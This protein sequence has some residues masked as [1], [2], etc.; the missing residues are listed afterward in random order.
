MPYE[1]AESFNQTLT[2]V[3]NGEQA[4]AINQFCQS[5]I[6]TFNAD[7]EAAKMIG[8]GKLEMSS[9]K[10]E[11]AAQMV[12]TG[13]LDV[14]SVFQLPTGIL[15]KVTE[16]A[17]SALFKGVQKKG[18]KKV[19][20][21][22]PHMTHI[23]LVSESLT[24]GLILHYQNALLDTKTANNPKEAGKKAAKRLLKDIKD[25]DDDMPTFADSQSLNQRLQTLLTWCIQEDQIRYRP[26]PGKPAPDFTEDDYATLLFFAAAKILGLPRNHFVAAQT[27]EAKANELIDKIESM[28]QE[29][30]N[31]KQ[32]V[33]QAL[34][35]K[36]RPHDIINVLEKGA[37]VEGHLSVDI[38]CVV[39][40]ISYRTPENDM[41]QRHYLE[42]L[43]LA[44]EHSKQM[45][46]KKHEALSQ[47]DRTINVVPKGTK[48][49]QGAHVKTNIDTYT[50][51][52]LGTPP[53]QTIPSTTPPKE[54]QLTHSE[55]MDAHASP[56]DVCS[57]GE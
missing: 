47:R 45:M 41:Q 40:V 18:Y 42:E 29:F 22:G 3:L 34:Q 8:T 46:D 24:L 16:K 30:D 44:F 56:M 19:A 15:G 26:R 37:T 50:A 49:E 4:D 9:S 7:V 11:E 25:D 38:N 31:V 48:I 33:E 54:T 6:A 57:P 10:K 13:A 2:Q 20:G 28:E 14:A 43:K 51:P 23:E 21:L 35:Q 52:V 55:D 32:I 5:F 12:A 17:I 27:T 1:N 36:Q 39:D 53:P